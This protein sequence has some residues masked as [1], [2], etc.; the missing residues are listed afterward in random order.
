MLATD[1]QLVLWEILTDVDQTSALV[2][3]IDPYSLKIK[4]EME[5]VVAD[6]DFSIE[7][8]GYQMDDEYQYYSYSTSP[9]LK[10]LCCWN[11]G[12]YL[13]SSIFASNSDRWV[14]FLVYD[15]ETKEIISKVE[16]TGD[17]KTSTIYT[18][19]P[20]SSDPKYLFWSMV[21]N[22]SAV[23][24]KLNIFSGKIES[25]SKPFQLNSAIPDYFDYNSE[26]K[27]VNI[28]FDYQWFTYQV[29]S[30]FD[31]EVNATLINI[32]SVF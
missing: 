27:Q 18:F 13:I 15:T 20:D 24:G 32:F 5:V 26:S 19:S 12:K 6:Q 11:K 29:D 31:Y 22:K 9:Q 21:K 4:S 1:N 28:W 2:V 16:R 17:L 25:Y 14:Y 23:I 7:D 10:K 30:P 3:V 8:E